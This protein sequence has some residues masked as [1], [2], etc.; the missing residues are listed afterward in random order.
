MTCTH[1][2]FPVPQ[3]WEPFLA[4]SDVML[5]PRSLSCYGL[6]EKPLLGGPV[7]RIQRFKFL[8]MDDAH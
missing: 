1:I 8:G 3:G 6:R 7:L 4:L 5:T 2:P